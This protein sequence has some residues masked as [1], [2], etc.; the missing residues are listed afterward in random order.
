MT[1]A[2]VQVSALLAKSLAFVPPIVTVEMLRLA[3]PVLVFVTVI[4]CGKLATF[5]ISVAKHNSLFASVKHAL[6]D[7]R[8]AA[9]VPPVDALT[10]SVAETVWMR[11]PELPVAVIV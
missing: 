5:N 4:V 11:E 6:F 8:L 2:P 3:V 10:E 1:V 7:E 9:G